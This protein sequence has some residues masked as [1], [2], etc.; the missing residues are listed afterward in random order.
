VAAFDPD[1]AGEASEPVGTETAPEREPEKEDDSAQN[2]EQ[3]S[4]FLH[5][6]D[7]VAAPA[8]NGN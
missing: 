1:I 2:D 5:R 3:F 7:N 4:E 6:A 8:V